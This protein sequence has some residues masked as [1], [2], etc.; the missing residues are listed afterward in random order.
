[1]KMVRGEIWWV[2]FDP[3][4]GTE[5][6]KTRPAIIVS[7]NAANRRLRGIVVV[8]V[9]SNLERIFPGQALVEIK[10]RPGKARVDQIKAVDKMRLKSFIGQLT[11]DEMDRLDQAMQIHLGLQNHT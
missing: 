9:T 1:M 6:Q 10:G 3:S 5:I 11:P 8:P 4:I 7:N 2:A